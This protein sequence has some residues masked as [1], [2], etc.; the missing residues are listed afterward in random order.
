MKAG[1]NQQLDGHGHIS[2][3]YFTQSNIIPNN[4]L[5]KSNENNS[6]QQQA[7]AGNNTTH[8]LNAVATSTVSSW[9][10]KNMIP[11]DSNAFTSQVQ[12]TKTQ[13]DPQN[14]NPLR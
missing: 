14:E 11:Q 10:R 8:F 12:S 7:S 9:Q 4:T 13:Q 6:I 3:S 5:L 1:S 2:A